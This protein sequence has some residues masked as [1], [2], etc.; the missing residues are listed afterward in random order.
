[1]RVYCLRGT[2][3]DQN[4]DRGVQITIHDK[5]A[6]I[7]P[8]DALSE[9]ELGF[10]SPAL[11]ACFAGRVPAVHDVQR[12]PGARGLV[13]ELAAELAERRIAHRLSE[14]VVL[15][16]ADHVQ[17]LDTDVQVRLSDHGCCLVYRILP[18]VSDVGVDAGDLRSRLGAP[19]RAF[20]LAAEGFLRHLQ[21]P[22]R[23]P[24]IT[25]VLD[26]GP[27][28]ERGKRFHA[29]VYADGPAPRR[30]RHG[31]VVALYGQARIP[32]PRAARDGHAQHARTANSGRHVLHAMH[33]TDTREP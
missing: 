18:L 15:H 9:G 23:L 19:V 10:H 7:T 30:L 27:V 12:G 3:G 26:D 31:L 28:R 8:V 21:P 17:I 5:A 32:A 16:H 24:Q 14:P 22:L 13:V 2:P 1:M 4:V 29:Q 20:H 33:T 25:R 6:T 11:R